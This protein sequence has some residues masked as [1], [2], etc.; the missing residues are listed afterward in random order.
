M[1]DIVS[2]FVWLL[3]TVWFAEQETVEAQAVCCFSSLSWPFPCWH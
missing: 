1:E 3:V 2:P